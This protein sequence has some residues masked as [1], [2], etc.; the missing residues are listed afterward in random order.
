MLFP[1]L[2]QSQEYEVNAS[3]A[4]PQDAQYNETG[5]FTA[6]A[7]VEN[8]YGFAS[9]VKHK[10]V[11]LTQSMGEFKGYTYGAG[12]R[13]SIGKWTG[14]AEMG[15]QSLS[16]DTKPVIAKEVLYHVFLPDFGVPPFRK[17]GNFP[18]LEYS[19]KSDPAIMFKIGAQYAIMPHLELELAYQNS[20][21]KERYMIWNPTFNGGPVKPLDACGCLWMG[22][23]KIDLNTVTL[24]ITYSF[25]G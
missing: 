3:V 8:W 12:Y 9:Y 11:R 16:H 6:R 23:D 18:L 4:F 25:G 14:F 7:G 5:T 17:D 20:K 2:A 13:E 24:G 22:S 15:I 1:L 10:Q 21:L 19:Y